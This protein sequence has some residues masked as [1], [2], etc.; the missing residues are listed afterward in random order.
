M[1]RSCSRAAPR[2]PAYDQR[3]LRLRDRLAALAGRAQ[4]SVNLEPFRAEPR[5]LHE[6]L[7]RYGADLQGALAAEPH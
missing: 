6:D 3:R 2:R 7:L 4:A 1:R 5:A